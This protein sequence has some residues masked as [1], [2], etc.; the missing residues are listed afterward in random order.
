MDEIPLSSLVAALALALLVAGCNND[1]RAQGS[2]DMRIPA[3]G[4]RRRVAGPAPW[5]TT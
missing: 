2:T 3:R 5:R 1:G 4:P